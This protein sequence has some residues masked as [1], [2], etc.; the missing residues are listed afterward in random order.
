MKNCKVCNQ[1]IPEGRLKALPGTNVCTEH[2]NTSAYVANIVGVGNPD[3]DHY[4]VLD[5][6]RDAR[7][8]EQLSHY[9]QQIGVYR[10]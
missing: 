10:S 4:E 9:K 2:S 6:I 3:D 1:P 5:I 7:A 8:A